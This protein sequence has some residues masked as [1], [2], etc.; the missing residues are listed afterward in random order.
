MTDQSIFALDIGT[1]TVI[2]IVGGG[3][4][5][6]HLLAQEIVKH[7]GRAMYDGQ[8]HGPARYWSRHFGYRH[9]QGRRHCCL[10]N[11][12]GLRQAQIYRHE[13]GLV[14]FRVDDNEY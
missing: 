9:H 10:W 8:I 1:R 5:K 6:F 13:P 2:G 12:Y 3:D 4:D 14:V 11:G 7:A